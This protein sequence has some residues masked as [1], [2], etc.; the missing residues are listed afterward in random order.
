MLFDG[1]SQRDDVDD[2]PLLHAVD[3]AL[4]ALLMGRGEKQES[5]ESHLLASSFMTR[6]WYERI[7]HAIRLMTEDWKPIASP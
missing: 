1:R 5:V 4:G 7:L 3:D 2:T 6:T